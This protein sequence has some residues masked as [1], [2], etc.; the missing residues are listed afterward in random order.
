[1]NVDLTRDPLGYDKDDQPVYLADIMP[2]R[3]EVDAYIDQY[4]TRD[5]FKQ[6]YQQV[7]TDSQAW[8]AI[9]TKTDKNYAWNPSSTYIQ[10]PPYFDNMQ[11]DLSI[12]PLEN[13]SVLAKFGDTV[14]TDHISP[15]G[16]IARLSPA[17]RYLEENGISYVDFN[18]YGSRRGNHEVM[19]RGTFANIR[20]KNELADGKI[21]GWTTYEGEILPIYD[22]AMKYKAA[23]I[24]SIVIAGKDYGMGSS[25]DWAA[26]GSN[27]LGVKVVLAESFERI[28]RSNLVMMGVL[29][30]QFLDGET[31]ESLGLTGHEHYTIDLPEDVKVGQVVTVHANSEKGSKEFQA[32]VRFDAEADIRYYRHGGILPMVVRKKLGGNV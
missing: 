24:G 7:F 27:L 31:A 25:R 26:K 2:S 29:P 4:V 10:N 12:K 3:E 18:S 14:T 22:A 8:N 21:G 1:M 20:I 16:N 23:G 28:H 30:L 5:L 11:E 17:A 15:A 13:L 32:L 9:E 6:E 19:M